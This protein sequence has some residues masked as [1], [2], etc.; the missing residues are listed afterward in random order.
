MLAYRLVQA[1]NATLATAIAALS[2]RGR[3]VMVGAGG[4]S[5]PFDFFKMPPGRSWRRA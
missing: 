1:K 3:L 5:I 2:W 4:G